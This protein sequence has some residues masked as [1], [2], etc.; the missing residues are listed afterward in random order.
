MVSLPKL[1]QT[2]VSNGYIFN[3]SQDIAAYCL[4]KMDHNPSPRDNA[5]YTP[6]HDAC[7]KG[8]L[9]IARLLLLYGA[10]VSD[11]AHGGIR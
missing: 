4:E 8:R 3:L 11:S 6:L 10:D 9:D 5:G 2:L 1:L 7:A